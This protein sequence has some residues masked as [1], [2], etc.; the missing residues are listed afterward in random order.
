LIGTPPYTQRVSKGADSLNSF[1]TCRASS[2]VGAKIMAK[3]F[4][5]NLHASYYAIITIYS[6]SLVDKLKEFHM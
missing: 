4:L 2:L 5:P 3:G 1:S 6:I